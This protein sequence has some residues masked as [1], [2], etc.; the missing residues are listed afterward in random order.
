MVQSSVKI[1][2]PKPFGS[3]SLE[4]IDTWIFSIEL[5][6]YAENRVEMVHHGVHA[7]LNLSANT[8]I[9]FRVYKAD[10]NSLS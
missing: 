8:D 3:I 2:P 10:L 5:Y 9:W 7:A 6:F 4:D 1:E